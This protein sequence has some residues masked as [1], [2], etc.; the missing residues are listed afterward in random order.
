MTNPAD[1]P[2]DAYLL[3]N[4]AYPMLKEKHLDMLILMARFGRVLIKQHI[5]P[6]WFR[7]HEQPDSDGHYQT[8][9]KY[10]NHLATLGLVTSAFV[11]TSTF[12][13]QRI[14]RFYILTEKG[15]QVVRECFPNQERER[16][17][18]LRKGSI[19]HQAEH[20]VEL[21]NLVTQLLRE[22][23]DIPGIVGINGAVEI[24]LGPEREP[25]CDG[26][27]W[28]RRWKDS[29]TITEAPI[30]RPYIPWLFEGQRPGQASRW[31]AIE[32]DRNTE[33]ANIIAAKARAYRAIFESGWWRGK[34][35]WPVPL[36]VVPHEGRRE[37]VLREWERG[38][39][40][41]PILI[42]TKPQLDQHGIDAPIWVEQRRGERRTRPF[43]EAWWHEVVE[44]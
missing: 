37:V 38:W 25:R 33:A 39:P 44:A 40:G 34:Y 32:I 22:L 19:T 7:D 1:Q 23:P 30:G 35:Q 17:T 9:R 2:L 13:T 31:Y 24:R 29:T 18:T 6:L 42:T 21:M 16:F 5:M 8:A 11:Y 4:A 27:V 43:F 14:G 28:I 12:P 20:Q 10:M 15:E 36:F 3:S 26:L 41:S